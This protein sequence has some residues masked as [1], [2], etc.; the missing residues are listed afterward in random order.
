[1]KKIILDGITYKTVKKRKK[2]IYASYENITL[3]IEP[4]ASILVASDSKEKKAKVVNTYQSKNLEELKTNLGKNAK[5]IYPKNLEDKNEEIYAIEFKSSFKIMRKI[6][7]LVLLIILLFLGIHFTKV[8]M[9]EH[10]TNQTLKEINKVKTNEISYVFIEI[11]PK[12]VVELKG[13]IVI[14]HA[15]L[16]EDCMTVFE[17]LE[18][19]NKDLEQVINT[20]YNKAKEEGIDVTAGVSVSSTNASIKE[21]LEKIDYVIYQQINKEEEQKLMTEV[22]DHK[23]IINSNHKKSYN[24]ELLEAYKKDKDYGNTYTCS[25][26][27]NELSCYITEEFYNKLGKDTESISDVLA[28]VDQTIDLM[29]VFDKFGIKYTTTGVEGAEL[30]GLDKMILDKIYLNG[31]YRSWGNGSISSNT[32]SMDG[33]SSNGIVS[34]YKASICLDNYDL[35]DAGMLDYDYHVLPLNKL[36][37]VDSSYRDSD[38]ITLKP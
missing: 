16:N 35:G 32:I 37:L 29:S 7:L 10:Q 25:I 6:L 18:I 12:M 14:D 38:V 21:K 33:G 23:E 26:N 1:M 20:L 28:L 11:N 22:V 30:I 31:D 3:D 24:E 8:K 4:K 36:N 13:N 19:K 9:K 5:N 34:S 27:N 17:S 2:C 15:C